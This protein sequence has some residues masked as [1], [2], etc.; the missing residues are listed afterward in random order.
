MELKSSVK[1]EDVKLKSYLIRSNPFKN[2]RNPRLD[3]YKE[4]LYV[5]E[6][7]FLCFC[8]I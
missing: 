5:V 6:T 1:T 2:H 3:N 7:I 8:S 4:S